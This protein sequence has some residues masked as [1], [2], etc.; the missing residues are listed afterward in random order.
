MEELKP[1]PPAVKKK[2]NIFF[3]F[4]AFLLSL[5]LVLGAVAAV[6]YRDRLNLDSLRRWFTYR[7]LQKNSSG[8]A[9]SFDYDSVGKGGFT[10]LG[11][12]LLVWS[13]A[14]TRLYAPDG[15]KFI[16]DA[17]SLTRP[18]ANG[19]GSAAVVYDAGGKTLR[20]Y[21]NRDAAFSLDADQGH[22]I[23]SARM[24]PAGGMSVVS[25]APGYRGVVTVYSADYQP[26]LGIRLSSSFVMDSLL[27]D[28]GA[29][30]AVLTAGE[31]ENTYESALALYTLEGDSPFATCSL[32]NNVI[33]DLCFSDG[34][35]WALGENSLNLVSRDGASTLTYDYGGRYLKDYALGGDGFAALLL[36]KYRA[37][38]TA[39]L[40]T[41]DSQGQEISS[42]DIGE[43]VLDVAAAGRYVAVLTASSLLLYTRDLQLYKTLDNASG[44]RNVV[45]RSDGTAFLIGGGTA[46]LYIPS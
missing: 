12:D 35:F 3:R 45:L 25:R 7:T 2:P 37:G 17:L 28:D 40:L 32:G 4:L 24:C 26:V 11:N 14:G 30:V 20:V 18:M 23:L 34:A 15:T 22:E 31:T 16:D 19:A 36:G 43:Q 39:S 44:A 1:V 10:A 8:Q 42:L 41:V 21:A 6:A 33:L 13:S 46:K 29:T 27:S 38:S 9:E 5:A